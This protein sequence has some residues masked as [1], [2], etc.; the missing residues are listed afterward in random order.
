MLRDEVS[1]LKAGPAGDAGP[2]AEVAA[3][4]RHVAALDAHLGATRG[5]DCD[6]N[7][8]SA[9]ADRRRTQ[10][11]ALDARDKVLA[12]REK[13]RSIDNRRASRTGRR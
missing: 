8:G 5:D 12:A 4:L 3:A 10:I 11:V 7:E 9:V 13:V 1:R 6:V 2:S